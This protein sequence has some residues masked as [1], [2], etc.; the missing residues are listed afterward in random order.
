MKQKHVLNAFWRIYP[1][2]AIR[3]FEIDVIENF[4]IFAGKHLCCSLFFS[5]LRPQAFL[6][7][8][9]QHSCFLVNIKK[10]LRT[11]SL[12]EQLRWLLLHTVWKIFKLFCQQ[13]SKVFRIAVI[14]D[15]YS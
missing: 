3:R 14:R 6:K 7:K 8:R 5:G 12:L 13:I 2:T 15:S 9:L 4:T 11:A 1:E 10:L